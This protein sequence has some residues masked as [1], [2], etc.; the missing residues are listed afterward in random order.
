MT[1]FFGEPFQYTDSSLVEFGI[2]E[3]SFQSFRQA[4]LEASFSR[5]YGGIHYRSDLEEGNKIGE[6]LGKYIVQKLEL[7]RGKNAIAAK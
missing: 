1:H 5:L 6:Q 2:K 3:R 4:A 7:R